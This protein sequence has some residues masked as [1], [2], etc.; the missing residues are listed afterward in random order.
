MRQFSENILESLNDGLAV[1]DRSGRVVRWNRQLEELYGLR[2]E[3]AVGRGLG[4]LFDN[5]IVHILRAASD[6][7]AAYYKVPLGTRHDPPRRLLVNLAV[8][9]LRDAHAAAVGTIVILEDISTRVQLEEQLQIS[10][11]MASIGLLAAGVAH[12]W[13]ERQLCFHPVLDADFASSIPGIA[14]AGDGAGIA[15]GTAAA[16]R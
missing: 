14:V 12:D 4:E 10:E 11:K 15:G 7:G 5:A 13:N 8:T 1:F 6:E 2:H 16:E 3:E 9:P